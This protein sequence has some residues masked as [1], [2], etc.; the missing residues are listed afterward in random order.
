MK[1]EMHTNVY[2]GLDY[3]VMDGVHS[4]PEISTRVSVDYGGPIF[5]GDALDSLFF[6]DVEIVWRPHQHK[7]LLAELNA[8]ITDGS[9]TVRCSGYWFGVEFPREIALAIQAKLKSTFSR[10]S[11]QESSFFDRLQ[12]VSPTPAAKENS[13]EQ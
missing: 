7:S 11:L 5:Q 12:I 8:Q 10:D 1:V 13:L 9:P 4:D 6:D 2:G 3:V